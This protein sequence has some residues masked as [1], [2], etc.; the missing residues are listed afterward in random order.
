[1]STNVL[2]LALEALTLV[3]AAPSFQT[4]MVS[5]NVNFKTTAS[6]LSSTLISSHSMNTQVADVGAAVKAFDE[7]TPGSTELST[8]RYRARF[9]VIPR[10]NLPTLLLFAKIRVLLQLQKVFRLFDQ[11]QIICDQ[12]EAAQYIISAVYEDAN[13]FTLFLT[14]FHIDWDRGWKPVLVLR[15]NVQLH[16]Q[17]EGPGEEWMF[18]NS[19]GDFKPV[20][21][22]SFEF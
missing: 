16:P 2:A 21:K 17:V 10:G 19:D 9:V 11:D 20:H 4:P 3:G 12:N 7:I 15:P 13:L 6:L 22:I 8:K 18:I 5:C 1:M 14:Q